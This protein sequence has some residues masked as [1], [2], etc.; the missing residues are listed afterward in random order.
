MKALFIDDHIVEEIDN[1]ARK[2]HPLQKF[3]KNVVLRPEHRWENCGIMMWT[4][5]AWIPDEAV[6]KTLYYASSEGDRSRCQTRRDRG[7]DW[8]TEFY[9]LCDFGRRCELGE[10]VV[11]TSRLRCPHMAGNSDWHREQHPTYRHTTRTDLRSSRS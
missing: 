7:T 11:R 10:T 1:L 5:P 4:T 8:W 3:D 9:M 2:L 6:F